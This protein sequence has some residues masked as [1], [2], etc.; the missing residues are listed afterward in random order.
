MNDAVEN[1]FDKSKWIWAKDNLRKNDW[2][3]FRREFELE[4]IPKSV[5]ARLAV[6]TR[7]FLYIN[8]K[9]MVWGGGLLRESSPKNGFYDEI[10][11]TKALVK[12]RNAIA[13]QC[14]Y[15]GSEGRNNVDSGAAGLLFEAKEIDI[16]SDNRFNVMRDPAYK[17]T[18]PPYPSMLFGGSNIGFDASQDI[19][20]FYNV[21]YYHGKFEP[22]TEFGVYP[23][24]PWNT[25]ELRPIPLFTFSNLIKAKK[26]ANTDGKYIVQLPNAMQVAP[27]FS[28]V[29]KGGE[30]I[31]IRTDRYTL[32][33]AP[34]DELNEYNGHRTEYICMAGPQEFECLDWYVGE[35]I[36]FT[37]PSDVKIVMLGYREVGY[38]SE[39]TSKLDCSNNKIMALYNKSINTLKVCMRD[40]FMDTPD[41]E[42]AQWMSDLNVQT[43][44]AFYAF[45]ESAMKLVKKGLTEFMNSKKGSVLSSCVSGAYSVEFPSQSLSAISELGA[46]A[47]YYI[48]T[49]DKEFLSL[50]F[51]P[52]AQY[53]LNWEMGEDGFVLPRDGHSRWFDYLYNIDEKILENCWYYSACKFVKHVG[54]ILDEPGY[55]EFLEARMDSIYVNF[56]MSFWK[57]G[58]YSSGESFDDRANALAVLTNLAPKEKYPEI[59]KL[60]MCVNNATPYMEGYILESLCKMGYV[61][62]AYRRMCSRYSEIIDSSSS[63]LWEDFNVLGSKAHSWSCGPLNIIFKYM[64]GLQVCENKRINLVPAFLPLDDMKF[65]VCLFGGRVSGIYKKTLTGMDIFIE[66]ATNYEINL[67]L[68]KN[69][70]GITE[71][72]AIKLGKGKHRF[73]L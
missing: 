38:D 12:G 55:D 10:E 1:I 29:A 3:V 7:Y 4:K 48:Y 18:A 23:S 47:N 44:S 24:A 22:A 68:K 15:Y 58:G 25:L 49:Q 14:N 67:L 17:E 71:D 62:A 64:V 39:V 51:E 40:N 21:D 37:I 70:L 60:L 73:S 33:G 72:K 2:I 11:I 9:L 35:Q 30:V 54:D 61:Q 65:T 31:D 41:R 20:T 16:Y 28:I 53:L 69:N 5:I 34:G 50:A 19:G 59:A 57:N 26:I 27:Y 42:R 56:D 43:N 13:L 8:G 6:D 52:M 32:K 63:T 45:D 46:V 36:I 66:N